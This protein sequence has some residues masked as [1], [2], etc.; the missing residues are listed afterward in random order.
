MTSV[1]G[2]SAG[3]TDEKIE[4]R[5]RDREIYTE[6][7]QIQKAAGK[8]GFSQPAV[9]IHNSTLVV[10]NFPSPPGLRVL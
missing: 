7:A 4:E 8:S 10:V 9:S 5:Q 2:S 6:L 1:N 3:P